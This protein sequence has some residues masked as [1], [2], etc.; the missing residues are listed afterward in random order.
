MDL[1][2]FSLSKNYVINKDMAWREVDGQILILDSH[3]SE[4]AHELNP[5][6]SY[7]FF[8]ISKGR[9]TSEI[10]ETLFESYSKETGEES[11]KEDLLKYL[12]ELT[13]LKIILEK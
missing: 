12:C 5:M 11:L 7:I 13:D 8:L 4:S 2:N 6:A 9:E 1:K 10:L 3:H